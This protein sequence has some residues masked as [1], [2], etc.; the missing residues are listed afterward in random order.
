MENFEKYSQIFINKSI[1]LMNQIDTKTRMLHEEIYSNYLFG[2][3]GPKKFP[4]KLTPA[5]VFFYNLYYGWREVNDSYFCLLDIEIYIGRF[6][7]ENTKISKIRHLTY[8]MENYLNELYILK[9][10][11]NTY[12]TKIGRLY[13]KNKDHDQ[14]QNKI[15]L[16]FTTVMNTIGDVIKTRSS[17]VH[18][19]RFYDSDLERLS[20][21][22][23]LANYN[24]ENLKFLNDTFKI[25]YQ[26][27]RR[28][29][30]QTIIDNNKTIKLFLDGCFGVLYTIVCDGEGKLK[31]PESIDA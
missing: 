11:L 27:V 12:F 18:Q 25:E 1:K 22:E 6:P 17:H 7:Y 28:R 15:N 29:F 24:D 23:R 14:I 26:I 30:K 4:A 31:Y 2:L 10:R 21:Q 8:H 9:E 16:L 19:E 20:S 3:E 5:H 13:R